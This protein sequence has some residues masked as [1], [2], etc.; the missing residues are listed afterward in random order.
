[1]AVEIKVQFKKCPTVWKIDFPV[2][3]EMFGHVYGWYRRFWQGSPDHRGTPEALGRVVTL[4]HAKD[5]ARFHHHDNHA[6]LEP[7]PITWG[8]IYKVPKQLVESTLKQLDHREKV[9]KRN[10]LHEAILI[11]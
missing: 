11:Q 2:E 6:H 5:M 4:I 9:T 8:R 10:G 3:E 1:M 7:N